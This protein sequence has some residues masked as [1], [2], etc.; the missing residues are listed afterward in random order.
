MTS[1]LRLRNC[2]VCVWA[3]RS[4]CCGG[5]SRLGTR[6]SFWSRGPS[7]SPLSEMPRC[8]GS[9]SG[10]VTFCHVDRPRTPTPLLVLLLFPC[11]EGGHQPCPPPPSSTGECRAGSELRPEAGTGCS[12]APWW[13]LTCKAGEHQNPCAGEGRREV[14]KVLEGLRRVPGAGEVLLLLLRPGS[15][16]AGVRRS[17][18]GSVGAG[19]SMELGGVCGCRC[20]DGTGRS[21]WVQG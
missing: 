14:C 5:W 1:D 13:S 2:D 17:R 16:G 3:P 20:E 19:V 21:L 9:A 7:P 11:L 12:G 18:A 15:V 4:W 8:P 6:P 10:L